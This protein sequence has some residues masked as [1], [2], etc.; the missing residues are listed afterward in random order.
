VAEFIENLGLF[1]LPLSKIDKQL[2]EGADNLTL[3]FSNT[4][5]SNDPFDCQIDTHK[6]APKVRRGV[7]KEAPTH[8]PHANY[9]CCLLI[10]SSKRV[11]II[12]SN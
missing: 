2:I 3:Y 1:E 4:Q 11:Q 8:R 10:I 5:L 9:S 6:S 12:L 7:N